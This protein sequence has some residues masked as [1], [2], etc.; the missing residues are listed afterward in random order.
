ML[1]DVCALLYNPFGPREF[2]IEHNDIGKGIRFEGASLSASSK[3]CEPDTMGANGGRGNS[4]ST[5]ENQVDDI[6]VA[7]AEEKLTEKMIATEEMYSGQMS[8]SSMNFRL[9]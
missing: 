7:D 1:F 8:N 4:V 6:G 3:K 9:S 2:D 5:E